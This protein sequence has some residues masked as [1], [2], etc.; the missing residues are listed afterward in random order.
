M[1]PEPLQRVRDERG[2]DRHDQQPEA[3]LGSAASQSAPR[4]GDGAY[5][6]APLPAPPVCRCAAAQVFWN[7]LDA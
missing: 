7:L 6:V 2:H 3:V 5:A 1:Q 4:R